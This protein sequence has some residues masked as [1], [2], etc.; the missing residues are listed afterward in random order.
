MTHAD[1][2]PLTNTP[3]ARLIMSQHNTRYG[4]VLSALWSFWDSRRVATRNGDR[5]GARQ[6]TYSIILFGSTA[7]VM[8]ENNASS[9]AE[10]LVGLL[11][12]QTATRGTHFDNALIGAREIVEM[13]TTSERTPVVIFLSDGECGLTDATVYDLCR[14]AVRAGSALSFH[15]VSFGS[16]RKSRPLRRMVEIATEVYD[17]APRGPFPPLGT[18]C[19]YSTALDTI[20]LAN[21]FLAIAD[22]LQN[23]RASLKK[24]DPTQ[25]SST[26]RAMVPANL[27][28][29]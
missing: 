25:T 6:D 11:L 24:R 3:M 26:S 7:E 20:Q 10:Q 5:S 21:T 22:S 8:T 18:P 28:G 19:S 14:S 17:S 29:A 9:T 12:N 2:Q 27:H 15:A 13:H 4:A 23:P 16:N 1:R